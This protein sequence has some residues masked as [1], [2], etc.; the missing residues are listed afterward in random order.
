MNIDPTQNSPRI[1]PSETR[2]IKKTDEAKPGAQAPAASARFQ[3]SGISDASQD[4]DMARVNE[5]RDAISQGKLEIRSDKIA[6]GLIASVRDL[7]DADSQ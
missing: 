4:I 1:V 2:D 7:L 3:P 6:D 5:I